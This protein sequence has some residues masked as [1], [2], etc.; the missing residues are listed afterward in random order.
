M[1]LMGV[2]GML[3]VSETLHALV[4]EGPMGVL[5][6]VLNAEPILLANRSFF[7]GKTRN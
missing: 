4:Q 5:T 6:S 7:F 1:A 2:E 3:P